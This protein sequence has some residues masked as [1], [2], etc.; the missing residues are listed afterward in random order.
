MAAEGQSDRKTSV[1]E[2][3][4]KERGVIRFLHVEK[5]EPIDIH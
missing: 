4:M 5:M 1:M 3:W 2:V